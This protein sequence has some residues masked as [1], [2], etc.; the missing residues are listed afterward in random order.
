MQLL[1]GINNPHILEP[2]CKRFSPRPHQL[3]GERRS[4]HQLN[5][6]RGLIKCRVSICLS[7]F[8]YHLYNAAFFRLLILVSAKLITR[9]YNVQLL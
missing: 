5:N 7:I 8:S 6:L 9:I 3:F 2:K 4:L 1:K